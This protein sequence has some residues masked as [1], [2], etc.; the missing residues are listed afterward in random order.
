MHPLPASKYARAHGIAVPEQ[1]SK[2]QQALAKSD[3][4]IKIASAMAALVFVYLGL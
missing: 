2:V 4:L 3:T 1:L